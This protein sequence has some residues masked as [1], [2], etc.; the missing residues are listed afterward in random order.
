MSDFPGGHLD[1]APLYNDARWILWSDANVNG[2]AVKLPRAPWVTGDKTVVDPTDPINHTDYSVAKEYALMHNDL[3]MGIVFTKDGPFAGVDIDNCI[4]EN[5]QLSKFSQKIIEKLKSYT[6][7]SPSGKGIHIIVR[8]GD[9]EDLKAVKNSELGL[10]IY[11]YDRYF[12]FTSDVLLG[13]PSYVPFRTEELMKLVEDFGTK[14][15][16]EYTPPSNNTQHIPLLSDDEIIM[17]AK[18]SKG[19]DKFQ[20]LWDGDTSDYNTHSEADQALLTIL[21]FWTGGDRIQMERLFSRS[22]LYREKWSNRKDYRIRSI[23]EALNTVSRYYN[24]SKC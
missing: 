22:S 21:A 9:K 20:R 8:V 15:E 12:T 5:R 13:S 14:K 23:N 7:I 18:M 2:R 24:P 11:P 17:K 19:G 10:E 3:D 16:I 4:G 1:D 6:E